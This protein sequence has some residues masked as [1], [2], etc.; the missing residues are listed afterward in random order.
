MYARESKRLRVDRP[1]YAFD[2]DFLQRYMDNQ[3]MHM[4]HSDPTTYKWSS[5]QE[6][7]DAISNGVNPLVLQNVSI[8]RCVKF[9]SYLSARLPMICTQLT[10]KPYNPMWAEFDGKGMDM[11]EFPPSL[12]TLLND[13]VLDV[14]DE[15]ENVRMI[16]TVIRAAIE[17]QGEEMALIH[18]LELFRYFGT[19]DAEEFENLKTNV[20]E[21]VPIRDD[22]G[23]EYILKV[24]NDMTGLKFEGHPM[25]T[26]WE[27]LYDIIFDM[28]NEGDAERWALDDD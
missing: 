27:E 21:R 28:E 16:W 20:R 2:H 15:I 13:H 8:E 22:S 24:Y 11:S 4:F 26:K 7:S 17:D 18:Q 19:G 5:E 1:L 9:D 25:F 23:K 6:Y 14:S 10:A 12:L 3:D